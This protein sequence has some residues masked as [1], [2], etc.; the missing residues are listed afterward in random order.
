LFFIIESPFCVVYYIFHVEILVESVEK[1]ND[2]G[3][4]F[5]GQSLMAGDRELLG[6]DL[7][8]DGKRL[9]IEN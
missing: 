5:V 6:V 2:L 8:S 3:D 9:K 1:G 4:F 7:L